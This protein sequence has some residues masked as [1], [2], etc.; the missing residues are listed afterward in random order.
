MLASVSNGMLCIYRFFNLFFGA[1]GES[2]VVVLRIDADPWDNSWRRSQKQRYESK[3]HHFCSKEV[4]KPSIVHAA[5][6]TAQQNKL[7]NTTKNVYI[8]TYLLSSSPLLCKV[9]S[10][11]F[12][13]T[14][15]K[16]QDY[17]ELV[18]GGKNWWY[19]ITDNATPNEVNEKSNSRWGL[20]RALRC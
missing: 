16:V 5:F 7:W 9:D 15:K 8:D 19:W 13:S 11:E 14:T 18:T 17:H 2:A 4:A 20:N 10:G 3:Q 12:S 1:R 6:V